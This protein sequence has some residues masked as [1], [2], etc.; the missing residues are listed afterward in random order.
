MNTFEN[1]VGCLSNSVGIVLDLGKQP[2]SN[3]FEASD[4][5]ETDYHS[6]IVGQCQHCGLIQLVKPMIEPLV[7]SRFDWISYNEPESHL[8]D[9]ARR[10]K[11]LPGLV[12]SSQIYGMSYKDDSTL[13][14]LTKLGLLTAE[15]L[16][17]ARQPQLY[18]ADGHNEAVYAHI[19][20]GDIS[21]E[22]SKNEFADVLVARHVLEHAHNP[23]KYISD[24]LTLVKPDGYLVI[25]V[26]ECGKFI[27]SCDYSFLWEEH[28]TYFSSNTLH[29]LLS[30]FGLE[31]VES[32]LYS[33]PLEDS[34]VVIVRKTHF[35]KDPE[36][37][38]G[39]DL[40]DMLDSGKVFGATFSSTRRALHSLFSQ[41]LTADRRCA[42][43]GA[44]H[45]STKFINLYGLHDYLAFV[46]DDN[47][48]KQ[49]LLMPGSRL[50]IC[51]SEVL[52]NGAVDICL[53]AL[54]PTSE[55]I[56]RSKNQRFI[57]NGGEFFS[58]FALGANSVYGRY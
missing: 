6:L 29:D 10:I 34:L 37:N 57:E 43:L 27:K 48:N 49:K 36:G 58:I 54:S 47:P 19:G 11:N 2:P 1:C 14:R 25:E 28:V 8:D 5:I 32:Q 41:W 20:P 40:S 38:S 35:E 26:P 13:S 50:P 30:N 12:R 16:H 17:P 55:G 22:H 45:L 42:I 3:R 33:Y 46:I 51:N 23:R 53:L 39:C 21:S 56:V 15:R 44:G 9:L 24:A 7:R 52:S 31:I 4:L 18:E